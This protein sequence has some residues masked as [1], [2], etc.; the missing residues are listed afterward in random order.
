[1]KKSVSHIDKRIPILPIV[2]VIRVVVVDVDVVIVLHDDE[3]D[4]EQF[5]SACHKI[6]FSTH[7][8]RRIYHKIFRTLLKK[9]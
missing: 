3:D 8:M 4:K 5:F 9:S 7:C 6:V 1:M 2:V